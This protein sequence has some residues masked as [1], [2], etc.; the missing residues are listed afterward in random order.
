[1]RDTAEFNA[2][3]DDIA[4]SLFVVAGQEVP[5]D[6]EQFKQVEE[7]LFW[8]KCAAQNEYD[9]DYFRALFGLL[10]RI[11]TKIAADEGMF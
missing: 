9:A 2:Y 10:A 3:T 1:M 5:E 4:R 7:G 11:D 8:L 6:S